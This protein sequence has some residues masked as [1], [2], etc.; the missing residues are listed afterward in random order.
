M[1]YSVGS[2]DVVV[3][4]AACMCC[5]LCTAAIAQ[6]V[7][8]QD[9]WVLSADFTSCRSLALRW[10]HLLK[11]VQLQWCLKVRLQRVRALS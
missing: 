11:Q 5:N 3:C 6:H 9:L 10:H 7:A 2:N 4:I 8:P 1:P